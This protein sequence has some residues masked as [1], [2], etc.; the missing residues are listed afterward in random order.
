MRFALLFLAL[1]VAVLASMV[2][3]NQ[4]GS[5]M[6][7]L[8]SIAAAHCLSLSP[9]S[10]PPPPPVPYPSPLEDL[11]PAIFRRDVGQSSPLRVPLWEDKA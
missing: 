8:F 2:R 5:N 7:H 11:S 1:C 6:R 10:S 4:R 9:F 3:E